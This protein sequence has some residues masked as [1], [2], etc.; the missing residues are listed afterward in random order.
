MSSATGIPK[1]RDGT[2]NNDVITIPATAQ[3]PAL[4]HAFLNFMLAEEPAFQNFA[5][6]VGYQPPQKSINPTR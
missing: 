5:D 6:W 2:V 3:N 4:A 1:S